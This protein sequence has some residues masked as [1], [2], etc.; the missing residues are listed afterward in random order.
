[1]GKHGT[2][3]KLVEFKPRTGNAIWGVR[4]YNYRALVFD[5]GIPKGGWEKRYGVGLD[6]GNRSL[7]TG[8]HTNDLT[9]AKNKARAM[10]KGRAYRSFIRSI[11][12]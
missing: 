2:E 7:G 8:Y 9:E 1:M 3:D 6:D 10:V 5:N 4:N 11:P 12:G